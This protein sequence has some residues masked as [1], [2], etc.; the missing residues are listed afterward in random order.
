MENWATHQA[1]SI[2]LFCGFFPLSFTDGRKGFRKVLSLRMCAC[3]CVCVVLVPWEIQYFFKVTFSQVRESESESESKTQICDRKI[4]KVLN[5]PKLIWALTTACCSNCR[6]HPATPGSKHNSLTNVIF[7]CPRLFASISERG[8]AS[9]LT[10]IQTSDL[11]F[12]LHSSWPSP[13]HHA[14]TG[15]KPLQGYFSL[16]IST[17]IYFLY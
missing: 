16:V 8:D 6:G 5:M 15:P 1:V 17:K 10:Q 4:Q 11:Q 2:F 9:M 7:L 12:S 14:G 13:K 3:V